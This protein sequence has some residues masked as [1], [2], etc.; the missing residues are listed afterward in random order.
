MVK[1]RRA[2]N[3]AP[4]PANWSYY[5]RKVRGAQGDFWQAARGPGAKKEHGR[6]GSVLRMREKAYTAIV[7]SFSSKEETSTLSCWAARYSK[8]FGAT[9][10]NMA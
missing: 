10:G 3:R 6:L 5:T 2:Q 7:R 9:L 4:S 1:C 8:N